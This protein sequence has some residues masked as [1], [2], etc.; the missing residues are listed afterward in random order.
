ESPGG[1]IRIFSPRTLARG[2]AE[3]GLG[4]EGV[5]FAH[6]LHTPYWALRSI[7]GLPDADSS[8]LVRGYREFLIRATQ[9]RWIG[10]LER[11]LDRVFPKSVVLYAEKR[12][13]GR[14]E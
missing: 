1:H 13:G 11:L 10:R 5:G 2:L 6:A 12:P 8:R 14:R 3:A 7:A 4:V 9:S